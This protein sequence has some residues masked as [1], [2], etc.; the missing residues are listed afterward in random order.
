METETQQLAKEVVDNFIE[1]VAQIPSIAERVLKPEPRKWT[2][3][4]GPRQTKLVNQAMRELAQEH[5]SGVQ[6]SGI[7][8]GEE[9]RFAFFSPFGGGSRADVTAVQNKIAEDFDYTVTAKNHKLIIA[10]IEAALPAIREA[11]PV[12]DQR[13]TPE[14]V[15]QQDQERNE[16]E[17][18]RE[19][20]NREHSAK[21]DE[22]EAKLRAQ[23]PWAKPEGKLSSQARAAANL[24]TEL[25][26]R[27]PGVN[28]SVKSESF[29]GG[30]SIHYSWSLGPTSDE[31]RDVADKYKYGHF[32]GMDDSYN[33]DHS[34]YGDAVDRVLGRAKYCQGGRNLSSEIREQ[35]GRLL[36][37]KQ[38]VEFAGDNTRNVFGEGDYNQSLSDHVYQLLAR[39]SFPLGSEITG[40]EYKES[41]YD[42]NTGETVSESGYQL[43]FS[44]PCQ[45]TTVAPSTNGS[46]GVAVTENRAKGGV[47]IRFPSK[48]SAEVLQRIKSQG[49]WR[50]SKFSKCWYAKANEYT[51]AFAQTFVE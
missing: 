40:L 14:D 42:E 19:L 4:A 48:P 16:R 31:V 11:R 32:D 17:R 22:I 39:T 35:V 7:V 8:G 34:A 49:G 1:E 50:W 18:E 41:G 26:T 38:Q 45:T 9:H 36:C 15:A 25:A 5:N 33:N 27:F 30:N 20:K 23:Y 37:E 28:F 6:L 29:S 43:L 13:R 10:A 44:E 3:E 12:R 2:S 21:V 24:R 46:N 47:E 51:R